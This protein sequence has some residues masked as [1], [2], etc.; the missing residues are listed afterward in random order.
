MHGFCHAWYIETRI[1]RS[2]IVIF[3]SKVLGKVGNIVAETLCFLQMFPL[4]A[5]LGKHCCGNKISFPGS[6][7]VSQQIQKHFCCGNNVSYFAHM[8]SNVSNTR[9]IVFP[10]GHVQTMFKDY[11]PN[12]NNALRFVRAN[13][14]QKMSTSLPRWETCPNID[15]K[16][17]FRKNVS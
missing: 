1:K 7:N 14:S 16:Q 2:Q 13:V 9:N 4:L 11:S 15:R 17:C 12:I 8:F 10:I 3:A 5:H 6:K